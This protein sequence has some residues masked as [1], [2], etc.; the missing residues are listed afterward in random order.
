M[1]GERETENNHSSREN[2]RDNNK[3]FIEN[4]MRRKKVKIKKYCN[5]QECSNNK[6]YVSTY[7]YIYIYIY[8]Y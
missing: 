7:I 8:I 6:C 5:K 1:K 2:V 3:K 4:N